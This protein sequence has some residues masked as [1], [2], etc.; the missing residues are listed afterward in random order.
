MNVL[1][2]LLLGGACVVIIMAGLR[3]AAERETA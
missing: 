1:N 2:Q 3:A